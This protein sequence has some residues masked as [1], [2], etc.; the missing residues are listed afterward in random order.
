MNVSITRGLDLMP[1]A[2]AE[3]L[4]QWSSGNGTPGSATYDGAANAAYVPSDQDFGGCIELLKTEATQKLRWMG[5]TPILPGTY[6]RITARVKMMSGIFPEVR[7]A[8]YALNGAGVHIAGLTEVAGSATLD[9]YG[10]I[11]TV[12][13][14]VGTGN[15]TGVDMIWPTATYGHFGIDLVGGSGGIV[16]VDD[17]TI[18]DVTEAFLRDMIDAVDVRDFGA[19]GDGTTDNRAAFAA[20]D[21][22]AD[23]RTIMVPDGNYFIASTLTITNKIRFDGTVT[24]PASAR[25]V[26]QKNFDLTTYIDAFGDE[27]L[28]FK[29]GFQALMDYSDHNGFDLKG[30]KIDV[31]TPIDMRD[32]VNDTGTFLIRRVL[33]NGQF[34]LVDDPSWA[35]TVRTSQASYNA[36]NPRVLTNVVNASQIVPGSQVTG[37]GVGREVFVK[38]VN[39]AAQSLELSQPL[40]GPA[41]TQSYTFTRHKYCLDFMG[42]DNLRRLTFSDI[43]FQMNGYANGVLLPATGENIQFKDCFF[44][45]AKEKCITS[46]GRACQDLHLDRCQFISNEQGTAATQRVSVG[47][48]VNANDAKIRDNRFQRMG[49]SIVLNGTGHMVTGNHVFQGDD[50]TNAPRTPGIVFTYEPALATVT[51]NYIDNCSI[52]WTNEHDAKPDFAS[53]LSFSQMTVTGN[54]FYC[55]NAISSFRFLRIKPFGTGHFILG[56]Q[57]NQNAF[58]AAGGNIERVEEWDTTHA[59]ADYWRFRNINFER[60]NYSGVTQATASPVTLEFAQ[61]SNAATWTLD[62]SGYLPFGGN[63]RIVSALTKVDAIQN[64]SNAVVDSMPYVKTNQGAAYKLV[65]LVW[66]QACRGTVECTVRVDRPL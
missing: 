13:G 46:P 56:F 60:N 65:Q 58:F 10:K 31:S 21:A 17:I 8:G 62:P 9:T 57:V 49:L 1:P 33:R 52:E 55:S 51:G 12:M 14:I 29:K 22:A 25:L 50:E 39:V 16:R 44:L 30:R 45:K 3:G 64:G 15:R 37:A 43:E 2:F 63:A 34:N 24:M 59:P 36:N 48:N 20:A 38:A 27:V 53:E 47:V 26:L 28:A 66:P 35:P 61:T 40:Y 7:V 11:A 6:L 5:Q 41:A 19:V 54:I 4:G 18:E 32:A 23:G 42:F